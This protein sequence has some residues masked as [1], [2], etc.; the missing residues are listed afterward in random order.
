MTTDR[1]APL[2]RKEKKKKRFVVQ[3][4]KKPSGLLV[5]LLVN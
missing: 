4:S 2:R 5:N 3:S 1:L